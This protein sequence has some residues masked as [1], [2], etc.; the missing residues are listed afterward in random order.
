M[1][2]E[3]PYHPLKAVGLNEKLC[4]SFASG[5]VVTPDRSNEIIIEIENCTTEVVSIE[6]DEHGRRH[7][8]LKAHPRD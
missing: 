7:I 6:T 8:L 2:D 5:A 3:D 4:G 1:N